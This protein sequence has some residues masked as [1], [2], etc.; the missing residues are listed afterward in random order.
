[1]SAS[2]RATP[3]DPVLSAVATVLTPA[4]RA[5]FKKPQIEISE[6]EISIAA[7]INRRSASST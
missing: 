1:M 2:S 5:L 3:T 4:E 6:G 7:P